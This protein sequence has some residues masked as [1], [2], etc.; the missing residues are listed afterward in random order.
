MFFGKRLTGLIGREKMHLAIFL[1]LVIVIIMALTAC[2]PTKGSIVILDNPNGSGF[3]MEYKEWSTDNK[4]ELELNKGDEL[5]IN[6]SNENGEIHLSIR[7]ENGSEAY[8]GN[9]LKS[10]SFT[11]TVSETDKYIIQISGKNATGSLSI[12]KILDGPRNNEASED[13]Y[14]TVMDGIDVSNAV[15]LAAKDQVSKYFDMNCVD[16]P[17][18]EYV[19]WRIEKLE[20]VYTYNDME[21]LTLDIYLM[22]YEHLSEAP[23][24]VIMAGGMYITEDNWVCPTYPNCT[25]LVF[26]AD[27]DTFLF[28]M[29]ENDC[30]PGDALFTDDLRRNLS[31]SQTDTP[32]YSVLVD[33]KWLALGSYSGDFPWNY[34][35]TEISRI[36]WDGDGFRN[37][38][39]VVCDDLEITYMQAGE[40][41]KWALTFI[42]TTSP[43]ISTFR[44]IACGMNETDLLKAYGSDLKYEERY[45]DNEKPVASYDYVYGYA[46]SEDETYN[47]IVFLMKDDIITGI[48]MQNLIDGRLFQ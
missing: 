26:N 4:C 11:V 38:N 43:Q 24:N 28:A 36:S 8:T 31:L 16:F 27:S 18:C 33:G 32:E 6:S 25:Y 10:H 45:A 5:Q 9:E 42:S 39:H 40:N 14:E 29:M 47:H 17:E 13:P 20:R 37:V 48:E 2:S 35:L 30:S 15:L 1:P 12:S 22:N 23:E 7:G 44:G 19:A 34:S 21:S 3:T 41:N 46:P